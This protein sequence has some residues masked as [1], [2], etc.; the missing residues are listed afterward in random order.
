MKAIGYLQAHKLSDFSMEVFERPEPELRPYDLLVEVKAVSVNPVDYKVRQSRSSKDG[1]PVILGWDGAGVVAALGP[2]VK[3]FKVGD[4]VYYAGDLNRDGSNAELQ[5]VD[6]RLAA[7]KPQ[8]L[9]F[10]EAVSLPLTALTAW[11]ALLERGIPYTPK[12]SALVIGGAGGVGSIAI[13]LLKAKTPAKVLATA[14]RPE[15][16]DW[17]KKMGADL[18]V[19]HRKP[20]AA[21]LERLGHKTVEVILGTTHTDRYLPV[22]PG[23]LSPF[24]HLSMIDDPET[25]DIAPFKPKAAN[26]HWEFMFAKSLWGHDLESQ[27]R[28]LSETARLVEE[29]KVK[30]TANQ[31]LQGFN[32]DNLRKAHELLESGASIGKIVIGF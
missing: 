3:N 12:T 21:E 26:L 14:S 13:Q 8:N 7:L 2:G 31:A 22:L 6:S 16:V 24:G 32:P 30:P 27:G 25:L 17:V 15:T 10:A 4:G 18:I 19:D 29:G 9:S 11:E 20:L 28:I 23:V 5:A 1:R